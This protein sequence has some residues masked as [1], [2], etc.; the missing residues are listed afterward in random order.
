M[1][2]IMCFVNSGHDAKTTQAYNYNYTLYVS[3]GVHTCT[4]REQDVNSFV[5]QGQTPRF[6][7]YSRKVRIDHE[8]HNILCIVYELGKY[9][10]RVVNE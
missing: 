8:W 5:A 9:L 10:P 7:L 2:S 3:K 6:A 4:S 1:I